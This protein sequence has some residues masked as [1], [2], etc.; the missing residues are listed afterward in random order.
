MKTPEETK[1]KVQGPEP[2][3]SAEPA[4]PEQPDPIEVLKQQHQAKYEELSRTMVSMKQQRTIMEDMMNNTTVQM[5][6]IR[7]A[8][9]IL[10]TVTNLKGHENDGGT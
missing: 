7:G 3:Q 8:L 5:A 10:E 4:Q 1:E 6:E 2:A 9:K